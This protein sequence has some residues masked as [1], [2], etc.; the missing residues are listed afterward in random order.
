MRRELAV[1]REEVNRI[2]S[3]R[4]KFLLIAAENFLRAMHFKEDKTIVPFLASL[5][6]Q[7]TQENELM[8]LVMVCVLFK[9]AKI[10]LIG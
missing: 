10:C 4:H 3:E 1:E 6:I 9:K 5:L 8:S 2:R 7:N